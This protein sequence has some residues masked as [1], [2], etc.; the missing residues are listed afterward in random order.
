[1]RAIRLFNRTILH[2]GREESIRPRL[3]VDVYFSWNLVVYI[4][5]YAKYTNI[6]YFTVYSILSVFC[7]R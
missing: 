4:L 3:F 6:Y 1:M 5:A 7:N 2:T